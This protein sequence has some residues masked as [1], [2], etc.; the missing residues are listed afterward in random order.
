MEAGDLGIEGA[1][2]VDHIPLGVHTDPAQVSAIVA[3]ELLHAT[4]HAPPRSLWGVGTRT[5]A[6]APSSR[7]PEDVKASIRSR[8]AGS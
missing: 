6:E 4:D 8:K 1:P 7:S 2:D 3:A 5:R